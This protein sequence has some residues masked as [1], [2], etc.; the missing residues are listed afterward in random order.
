MA[1]KKKMDRLDRVVA[2][3]KLLLG[4]KTR[5]PKELQE[6]LECSRFTVYRCVEDAQKIGMPIEYDKAEN[7]YRLEKD[8]MTQMPYV[9]FTPADVVAMI[10]LLQAFKEIPFGILE[11]GEKKDGLDSFRKKLQS[12]I[13][14]KKGKSGE[15]LAKIKVI[16]HAF[17][18]VP[19]ASLTLVCSAL[20]EKKRMK[21]KYRERQEGRETEREISPI[22]LVRYRDNWYLDAFCHT[23]HGLRIFSLDRI[24]EAEL[25]D[26]AARSVSETELKTFVG[27]SYGIFAGVPTE[28]AVLKFTP[29]MAKWV[30][31]EEWHP[32]QEGTVNP[33]GSYTLKIPY[34]DIRELILDILRYGD[35]VEVLGPTAL[36]REVKNRLTR[37]LR[38]Y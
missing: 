5:T 12:F 32:D 26:T 14:F 15:F 31:G 35:E 9:W 28:T 17:R 30:S 13:Q 1:A 16:P 29:N 37:A 20:S 3:Q 27:R 22:Q 38:Q 36:K 4:G 24:L 2:M 18:R 21:M 8:E 23:N 34:A 11:E 7:L 6:A 33:D 25:L 19:P 10:A